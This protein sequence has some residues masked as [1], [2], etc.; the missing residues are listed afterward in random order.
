MLLLQLSVTINCLPHNIH[1]LD[2]QT[3][4]GQ[5]PP[6]PNTHTLRMFLQLYILHFVVGFFSL[7][8]IYF[9]QK[10]IS[11]YI[12]YAFYIITFILLRE[13]DD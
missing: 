9:G 2:R 13:V 3:I 8:I 12:L 11:V 7:I 5:R 1:P 4:L 6:A 10:K